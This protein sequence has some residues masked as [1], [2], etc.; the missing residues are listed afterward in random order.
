[1]GQE[2]HMIGQTLRQRLTKKQGINSKRNTFK[3]GFQVPDNAAHANRVDRIHGNILW[4]DGI[5]N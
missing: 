4:E 5:I 2:I 3:L 1:M